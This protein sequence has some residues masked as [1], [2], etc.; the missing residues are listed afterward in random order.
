MMKRHLVR[1]VGG[2]VLLAALALGVGSC[3]TPPTFSDTTNQ[4]VTFNPIFLDSLPRTAIAM[5]HTNGGY[6]ADGLAFLVVTPA[7]RDAIPR[8]WAYQLWAVTRPG[9]AI[10]DKASTSKFLWD[11]V[12]HA[13]IQPDGNLIE[14]R[15]FNLGKDVTT[16]QELVWTIEPY[17]DYYVIRQPVG[18]SIDIEIVDPDVFN[19]MPDLEFLTQDL[20]SGQLTYDV[21]FPVADQLDSVPGGIYF[22]ANVTGDPSVPAAISGAANFGLWFGFR[23]VQP[24]I[25]PSLV[26][27]PPLPYGWIYQGWILPPRPNPFLPIST[28]R[29]WNPTWRDSSDQYSGNLKDLSTLF[30]PGEDFLQNAPSSQWTFPMNLVSAIGDTGWVYVSI[31]PNY[32]PFAGLDPQEPSAD[33]SD[34]PFFFRALQ[35]RLP[36]SAHIP[37]FNPDF[38]DSNTLLLDNMHT[39]EPKFGHGGA[40]TVEV[41]ITSN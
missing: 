34:G 40:P 2:A 33:I 16:F 35:G 22:L 31:E 19:P 14:P 21:R 17:P 37:A 6:D 5:Q 20:R 23:D 13:A 15:K 29:F 28:G 25:L 39:Q 18:D 9:G 38:P 1:W 10:I 3:T 8:L 12:R 32:P 4:F 11:P 36:D 41:L 24:P 27:L 30:M 26:V 7:Q